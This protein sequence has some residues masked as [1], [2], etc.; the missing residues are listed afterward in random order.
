[1]ERELAAEPYREAVVRPVEEPWLNE[2]DAGI[3]AVRNAILGLLGVARRADRRDA[4]PS[5]ATRSRSSPPGCAFEELVNRVAAGLDLPPLRKLQPASRGAARARALRALDPAQPPAGD[6]PA[7]PVSPPR[8]RA[9]EQLTPPAADNPPHAV[10]PRPG[11]RL[12]PRRRPRGRADQQPAGAAPALHPPARL[13]LPGLPGR[14]AQPLQPRAP[15]PCTSP[16]G[17]TTPCAPRARACCRGA[18]AAPSA[19]WCAPPPCS[20]TSATRRSA[21]PPR[22]CSRAASTTRR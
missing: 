16:A 21:T 20:T 6:R 11:P 19:G 14:G 17:S 18:T 12:H 10:D 13:H 4:S 8:R 5:T 9:L 22:S 3:L 1:M 7:A 2:H 15:A